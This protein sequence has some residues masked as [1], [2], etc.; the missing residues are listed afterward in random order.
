MFVSI[1]YDADRFAQM[2]P[3]RTVTV[4]QKHLSEKMTAVAS[5]THAHVVV[6]HKPPTKLQR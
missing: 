4:D 2:F 5:L 6:D 3:D 1:K